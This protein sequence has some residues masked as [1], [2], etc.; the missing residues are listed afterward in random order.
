[1]SVLNHLAAFRV[2]RHAV[3]IMNNAVEYEGLLREKPSS[4]IIRVNNV[5]DRICSSFRSPTRVL[6]QL[7]IG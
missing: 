1:M 6:T 3:S 2:A 7:V 5:E 4:N